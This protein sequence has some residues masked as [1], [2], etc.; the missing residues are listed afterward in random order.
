MEKFVVIIAGPSG[1]GKTTVAEALIERLGIFEMSRSATTRAKRGDGKDGEY[2]YLTREEF[3]ESKRRGDIL[4]CTDYGGNLYG[5]RRSEIEAIF[6]RGKYP[7]LVLDYNGVRSLRE[8]MEYPV[9]AFYIYTSLEEAQRR[10][11]KREEKTPDKPGKWET[12]ASRCRQNE[13]DFLA[14][15][16]FA[17]LFDLFAENRELDSCFLQ[18]AHAIERLRSGECVMT[19]SEKLSLAEKLAAEAAEKRS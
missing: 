13:D 17:A 1:A 6:E 12:V 19:D 18:V 16:G 15:P 9:Y 5:T 7:M 14:S 2:V 10:L 3:S 8:K 4:E 11:Y